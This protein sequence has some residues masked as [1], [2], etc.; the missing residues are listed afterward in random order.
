MERKSRV[1]E[2]R[3]FETRDAQIRKNFTMDWMSELHFDQ[4]EIPEG[5]EYYWVRDTIYDDPC[6]SRIVEMKRRGWSPVPADRHPDRVVGSVPWRTDPK[7]GFI[8]HRGL[9]LCER[10]KEYG[11]IERKN[12]HDVSIRNLNSIPGTEEFTSNQAMPARVFNNELSG[13]PSSTQFKI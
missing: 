13:I 8:Y 3:A 12:Y 4:C 10:P 2:S 6:K 5:M 9:V 11:D 1:D 7:A